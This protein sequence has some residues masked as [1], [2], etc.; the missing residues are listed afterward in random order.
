MMRTD[1]DPRCWRLY[2]LIIHKI[3][4]CLA[5]DGSRDC[6]KKR[7]KLTSSVFIFVYTFLS[8]VAIP[9]TTAAST[10]PAAAS[11]ANFTFNTAGATTSSMNY[12][13]QSFTF[14]A[15]S[16]STTLAFSGGVLGGGS[17]CAGSVLDNVGVSVLVAPSTPIPAG[18]ALGGFASLAA[19]GAYA[20]RRRAKQS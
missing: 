5:K 12:A 19:F 15:T 3:L 2:V 9:A 8:S 6:N 20:L 1:H 13:S 4:Q 17:S 14:A 10:V 18:G 16:T 11:T 7:T